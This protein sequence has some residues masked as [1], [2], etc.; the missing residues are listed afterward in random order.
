MMWVLFGLAAFVL[1][2]VFLTRRANRSSYRSSRSS[3]YDSGGCFF[4]IFGDSN[5]GFCGD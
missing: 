2:A 3:S 5:G 4:D 1:L